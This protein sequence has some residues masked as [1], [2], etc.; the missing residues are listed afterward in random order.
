VHASAVIIARGACCRRLDLPNL[1]N[2]EGRGVYHWAS[3]IE[4]KLWKRREVVVEGGGNSAGQG[5]VY[6]ANELP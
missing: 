5:T 4:A 1:S 6:L 2:F 3:A